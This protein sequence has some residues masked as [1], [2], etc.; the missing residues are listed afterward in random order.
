[1]PSV[2][3][4]ERIVGLDWY[5]AHGFRSA[6]VV[7]IIHRDSLLGVLVLIGQKPLRWGPE[8]QVL[9][10][11]FATQAAIAI[12]NARLYEEL[13]CHAESLEHEVAERAREIQQRF[14]QTET[15]LAVSQ[16]VGSTLDVKEI[17]RLTTRE[18]VRA[19]G[20]DMGGAWP[21]DPSESPLI[22]YVGYHLPK[23]LVETFSRVRHHVWN[24]LLEGGG[25]LGPICSSDSRTAPRFDHSPLELIPHKSVLIVPLRVKG[26]LVGGIVVV[27][28]REAHHFTPEELQLVEGIARQ[29]AVAL[30][31]A[32][33]YQKIQ[34]AYDELSRTQAQLI[35]A[36]KMEGLGRLASG[37]AHEVRNPLAI[38]SSATQILLKRSDDPTIRNECAEKIHT[39]VKRASAIIE[40]LLRFSRPSEVPEDLVD[41]NGVIEDTLSL[42]GQQGAR[43]FVEIDRRL[44]PGLPKVRGN[45]T[46]L[47]QVFTNVLL[48]AYRAMP[49]GGRITIE[50]RATPS[51]PQPMID[52]RF[53]DTGCGIPEEHLPRIFEPFF[54]TM[55]VGEGTG[56]GLF[57]AYSIVHNHRDNFS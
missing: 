39:G 10:Q 38:V 33:L 37:I 25:E 46:Q 2:F 19:L 54:T 7:P 26:K 42:I 45:G 1:V 3:A 31:N 36:Q 34:E 56:L 14:R 50:S 23:E 18:M 47:Q 44:T 24:R 51:R 43:Q 28:V 53:S 16:V 12:R 8:T 55:P 13:A 9:L 4:D 49:E 48:N 57:V 27:W 11:S 29:A 5:R 20:A 17:V 32:R 40:N 6:F 22:G 35:Q 30:E 41:I 15:L 21:F 52:V